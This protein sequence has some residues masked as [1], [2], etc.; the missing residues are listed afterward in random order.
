M[1][2]TNARP[3]LDN[4]TDARAFTGRAEDLARLERVLGR[5][6]N[7]LVVGAP[8]SG[9]T[10]L[11]HMLQL[12]LRDQ[13]RTVV[14]VDGRSVD[15]VQS[16]LRRVLDRLAV[17]AGGGVH[18][19]SRR[20]EG[21]VLDLVSRLAAMAAAVTAGRD[22][23]PVILCDE[24]PSVEVGHTLFGRLRDDLW[25]TGLTWVLAVPTAWEPVVLEPPADAFFEAT[26]T[27]G[28]LGAKDADALL[29]ARVGGSVARQLTKAIRAGA[30]DPP[31]TPRAL[32]QLAASAAETSPEEAVARAARR[33]PAT[34]LPRPE[35]MLVAELRGSGPASASD[36]QLL[37]RLGWT[38][39][40]AVQVLRGLAQ[41]GV[42][43]GYDVPNPKGGR[44]LKRYRLT[45]GWL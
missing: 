3:L 13:G 28:A 36:T 20:D 22:P 44:P 2:T 41:K 6:A 7:A 37:T 10:S 16:L 34:D 11:L 8:G 40:R 29:R 12:R 26:I 30:L 21:D 31:A 14:F 23:G 18:P 45:E 38:R 33:D 27:L 17:V 25:M 1:T 42:V 4:V 19:W 24:L 9:K 43:T 35:A 5:D 15:D 39:S 32:L